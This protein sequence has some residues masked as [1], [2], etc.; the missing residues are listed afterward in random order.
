MKAILTY[1]S[2]DDS[3]SPISVTPA[4]FLEHVRWLARSD[5]AVVPLERL[6]ALPHGVDAVA[7]TFDDGI[8]NITTTAIPALAEHGF[9]ATVFV[10]SE[11]AGTTNAWHGRPDRGIP[12]LPLLSWDA[13]ARMGEVGITI[14]SHTRSHAALAGI[15]AGSLY[16][17]VEE[18]AATILRR[19]GM[20]PHAFA[21]PY[22]SVDAAA[23]AAVRHSYRVA[24]TTRLA[25]LAP[26]DDAA[27]LP[28]LDAYYFRRPGRL[29]EWGSARFAARIRTR[30]A[31]R[32]VR[33]VIRRT[34]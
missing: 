21:Y 27:L 9:P 30:A 15:D 28:R 10:V 16:D 33:G 20:R 22:G 24:C 25:L 18:S 6:T 4:T 31:A 26:S 2:I 19:T 13:L 17:E 3:T 34:A 1:H 23:A 14:G 12:V 8:A 5:I 7:I 32:W 29:A 11:R